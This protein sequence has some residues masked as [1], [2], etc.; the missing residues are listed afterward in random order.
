LTGEIPR[1]LGSLNE[2]E[3]LDLSG[4]TLTGNIPKELGNC[5]GL[6][7]LDLS[8]NNLSGEIP[9]EL[10]NLMAL[11][12]LLDLSSNSLS[13]QIPSNIAKLSS[14]ES[15][16]MSHNQ[17]SGEIPASFYSMVSLLSN[18]ID[19]SYNKLIG[20][21]PTSKAFEEAPA[22]AYVG[23]SGLCGNA[24]GLT[25]CYTDSKKKRHSNTLL[26]AVLIP[27]C[28][29][30][31]LAIIVAS[32]IIYCRKTK[33][34]DEES[35][36]L[37]QYNEDSESLIWEREGKFTFSDIVKATED[38]DEK[39]CIGK[40]GFGTVYKAALA[41]G[42]IVAVK[43]LNMSDSS[44]IP[45]ANRQ[46]FEN[47]IRVLTEVRHRNIIKLHG[48]CSMRGNMYLVYEYVEKGSLGNVLYGVEGKVELNWNTRVKILQGLAHAIAYLHHDCS[49]PIVHR[50]ITMNNILLESEF[51]PRLSDFG[52]ARLLNPDTTNWTT[53]AGSYGYMAPG[54]L[55]IQ[56]VHFCEGFS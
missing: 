29:I 37:G 27:V 31:F 8:N 5:Y 42:Q 44:D 41:T 55:T 28:G 49:P 51:E 30:L 47:E 53:I 33:F 35:R 46:S 34:H 15:L 14:L 22:K 2:L 40:G 16:N 6:F 48:F 4:N 12:Y 52:I 3:E 38:F 26:L 43:R 18:S 9:S 19:F 32:V 45:E 36:R 24:E 39:Y 20:Q 25:P 54:K 21:I 1:N 10:G 23:N 17:L 13:G 7:S 11:R 50:D 56:F